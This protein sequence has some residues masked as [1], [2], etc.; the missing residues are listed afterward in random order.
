MIIGSNSVVSVYSL[1]HGTSTDT[2]PGTA[3][4]SG[5]EAY[6]ESKQADLVQ[7]LGEQSNIEVF[8]MFCDPISIKIGDKVIDQDSREYRITGVERHEYNLDVDDFYRISMHSQH[9]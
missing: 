3:T 6:I 9:I 8:D 2:Y 5:I 4:L 1:A 7:V